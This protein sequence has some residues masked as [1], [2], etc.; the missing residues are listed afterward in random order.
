M[1]PDLLLLITALIGAGLFAGLVAG[2]FGVGGGVVIVPV[3]YYAQTALGYPDETRMHVAVAT[4]A[5]TI[6]ATSIR[7]VLS[8][9]KRGAVDW[10]A[11]KR[12]AP[13]IVLGALAGAFVADLVSGAFLT[14]FFG[15]VAL[16]ISAQLFF[17]RPDWRLAGD[18]PRG[19]VRAVLGG[20][21]G[22]ASAMMGI[23]GGTFGV[24]L[25]TLFGR[26]IHKAVGTAAGFGVAIGAPATIGF[27]I[28]GWGVTDVP[29]WSLGYVS[30]PGFVFIAAL[31]VAMA[32]AGVALAHRLNA[33]MLRRL[34]AIGLALTAVSLLFEAF[35]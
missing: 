1:G 33:N 13:W 29:P 4:S 2:L 21:I 17:G 14:G 32:P 6:I 27:I 23:G 16:V 34:F 35:G 3:L 7:S 20:G 30:I 10:A 18:L 11:L 25:M 9:N 22:M 5:A 8:H 12:W 28:A 26:P 15:L 19:G 31:T 24:L